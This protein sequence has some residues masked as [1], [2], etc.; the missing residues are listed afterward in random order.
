MS[1]RPVWAILFLACHSIPCCKHE[2]SALIPFQFLSEPR[3]GTATQH[4]YPLSRRC[5]HRAAVSTL[6]RSAFR[7][8]RCQFRKSDQVFFGFT[9]PCLKIIKADRQGSLG[10]SIASF[11]ADP[12][13]FF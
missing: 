9:I 1:S 6:Q 7:V 10:G 3:T 11:F 2:S 8:P 4:R 5:Q 12:P 13:L